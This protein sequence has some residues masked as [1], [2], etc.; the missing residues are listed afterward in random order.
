MTKITKTINCIFIFRVLWMKKRRKMKMFLLYFLCH[1]EN[2]NI[3]SC[4]IIFFSSLE[5]WWRK[6]LRILFMMF[7][8]GQTSVSFRPPWIH[9]LNSSEWCIFAWG[10]GVVWKILSFS[11]DKICQRRHHHNLLYRGMMLEIFNR[12][13]CLTAAQ[14]DEIG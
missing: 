1:M 3:F 5:L 9:L 11:A 2:F 12:D 4:Y 14:W 8:W 10:R 6:M 7:I 13:F